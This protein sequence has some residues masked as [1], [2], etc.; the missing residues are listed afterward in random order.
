[1]SACPVTP[2]AQTTAPSSSSVSPLVAS[3]PEEK[4]EKICAFQQK[5]SSR[6]SFVRGCMDVVFTKDEMVSSN[7][8]GN[9]DKRKLDKSKVKL[10][11]HKVVYGFYG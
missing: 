1:M 10:V 8:A 9:H 6:T 2:F 5:A 3:L 11:K 4:A 7:V